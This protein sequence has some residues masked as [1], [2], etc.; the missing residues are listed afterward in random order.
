MPD[1]VYL[2]ML[3]FSTALLIVFS[4][5]LAGL[6]FGGLWFVSTQVEFL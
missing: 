4:L 6:F 5:V 3:L 1:W 2:L